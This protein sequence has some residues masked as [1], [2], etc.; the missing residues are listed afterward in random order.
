MA[1]LTQKEREQLALD[2]LALMRKLYAD[3]NADIED[4]EAMDL[5]QLVAYLESKGV[6]FDTE[7]AQL[8]IRTALGEKLISVDRGQALDDEALIDFEDRVAR[9]VERNATSTAKRCVFGLHDQAQF[10]SDERPWDEQFYMWVSVGEG[11]CGSC[12]SLHGFVDALDMWEDSGKPRDGTTLCGANCRCKLIP[13]N[14][15]QRAAGNR[16]EE[17]RTDLEPRGPQHG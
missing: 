7:A 5:D 13:C 9:A 10:E 11:V 15:T 12:H 14:S 16:V 2:A 8:E 4:I 6:P 1:K 3:I 17:A